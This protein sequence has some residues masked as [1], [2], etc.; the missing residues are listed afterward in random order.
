MVELSENYL[1]QLRNIHRELGIPE[2]YGTSRGLAP[3]SEP[4]RLVAT[5]NDFYDRPQRLIEP[6]HLAWLAMKS[7]AASEDI[8]LYLISAFRSVEQQHKLILSKL[9][10]GRLLDDILAVVAAPGYSEHHTGRAIDL[11]TT[12]CQ[13]LEEEFEKTPAFE[14]L[15]RNAER[16][17]F[18]LSYPRDNSHGICYEPWHWCFRI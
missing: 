5:E 1:H 7:A 6:A 3:H 18:H 13:A 17:G 2:D 12:D 16:F 14:W 9:A 10:N 15:T 8:P 4:E 11:S